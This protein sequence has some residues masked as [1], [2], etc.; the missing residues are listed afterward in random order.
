MTILTFVWLRWLEGE[1]RL[2]Q[3]LLARLAWAGG[4]RGPRTVRRTERPGL[5]SEARERERAAVSATSTVSQ[6]GVASSHTECHD[7]QR[8]SVTRPV[9]VTLPSHSPVASVTHEPVRSPRR[10]GEAEVR[11]QHQW[12]QRTVGPS[13][14][15]W[16]RQFHV[17][18]RPVNITSD[19]QSERN[20]ERAELVLVPVAPWPAPCVPSLAVPRNSQSIADSDTGHWTLARLIAVDTL[21]RHLPAVNTHHARWDTSRLKVRHFLPLQQVTKEVRITQGIQT[22]YRNILSPPNELR[23]S[24]NKQVVHCSSHKSKRILSELLTVSLFANPWLLSVHNIIRRSS[25]CWWEIIS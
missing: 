25:E 24:L 15:L 2:H 8:H 14:H 23:D 3:P 21:G 6:C 5:A 10:P 17:T 18:P 22:I 9:T 20:K 7:H 13:S 19:T 12:G 16:A 11:G 4:G 1:Q